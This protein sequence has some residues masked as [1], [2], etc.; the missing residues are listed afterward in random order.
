[1]K[2]FEIM[3]LTAPRVPIVI[4]VPHAGTEFPDDIRAELKPGLLPP[5][6]T[7]WFVHQLYDF[8]TELG[9]PIIKANYSRWVVDLN[10]NPD[11][12]PL[13]HDGRV[14]TGLCTSTTF[15]GEPIYADERQEV[16]P[17][18]VARRRTMYFEPYHQ[19][20]QELLDD[21]HVLFGEVLLWDCHSI[22]RSVP[23]IHAGPFPDLILGSADETSASAEIIGAA[24]QQ[25]GAGPYSLSHNTP[26]KGGYITRHFGRPE[27]RQHALQL[28]MSKDLY[29]DD[30]EQ[31]YDEQRAGQV[32]AVLRQTLLTLS[33]MLKPY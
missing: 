25:L 29:M 27:A 14:L 5:D 3:P 11:S 15:L 13:Y 22:R 16:A 24:L 10:R 31:A 21:T 20:L 8:A 23:A 30:A 2:L 19:A 12:S 26:F 32:Q 9:I 1:M 18:E 17:A 28:E 4:S 7:D 33:Q 6:D